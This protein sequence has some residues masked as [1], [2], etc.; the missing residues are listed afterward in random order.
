[1][2]SPACYL[3]E[4]PNAYGCYD[5]QC[6]D[7]TWDHECPVGPCQIPEHAHGPTMYVSHSH[8]IYKTYDTEIVVAEE[9]HAHAVDQIHPGNWTNLT[10]RGVATESWAEFQARGEVVTPDGAESRRGSEVS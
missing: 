9:T 4:T 10:H 3:S 6:D 5:P 2:T 7:G 1:M 8:D